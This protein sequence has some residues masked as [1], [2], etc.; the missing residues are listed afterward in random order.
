MFFKLKQ[1]RVFTDRPTSRLNLDEANGSNFDEALLPEDSWE[2]YLDAHEFEVDKIIDVPS[3]RK[4]RYGRIH[5][6]YLV[7]WKEYSDTTWI[8]EA[9]LY[10]GAMLQ[11]FDSDQVSKNSF[12]VMQSH[13]KEAR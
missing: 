9:D 13:E 10:C 7:Q 1:V 12:E 5:K 6:Q 8:D 11:E 3:G 2:G 4:T